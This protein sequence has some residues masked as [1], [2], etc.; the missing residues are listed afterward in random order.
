[1]KTSTKSSTTNSKKQQGTDTTIDCID[2]IKKSAQV[3]TRTAWFPR[4]TRPYVK[5]SGQRNWTCLLGTITKDG[6]RFFSRFSM[7]VTAYH[8]K[9]LILALYEEFEDNLIIIL[10]TA[11]YF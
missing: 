1:M 10:D 9:H 2:Q 11:S 6:D 3:E 7:Y 4:C 5:L 8:T